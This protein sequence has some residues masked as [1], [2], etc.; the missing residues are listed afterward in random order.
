MSSFVY[1]INLLSQSREAL[2]KQLSYKTY[3]DL[4]KTI[5]NNDT[6]S[7]L[8]FLDNLLESLSVE[9]INTLTVLDKFYILTF[10]YGTNLTTTLQLSLTCPETKKKFN[11][12]LNLGKL[13]EQIDKLKIQHNFE[14]TLQ[15][16]T[17]IFSLPQKFTSNIILRECLKEIRLVGQNIKISDDITQQIPFIVINKFNTWLREQEVLLNTIDFINVKSPHAETKTIKFTPS[18]FNNSLL[19]FLIVIYRDDLKQIYLTESDLI[20]NQNFRFEDFEKLSPA[21]IGMYVGIKA[22]QNQETN[23]PPT[24]PIVP[25]TAK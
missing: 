22:K 2:F 25:P 18:L 1:P 16:I 20:N 17:Y 21:E 23:K 15:G 6:N 13:L 10:I 3:K 12:D 5:I 19:D 24:L 11:Y 9:K 14:Y 4:I 7:L 8:Y